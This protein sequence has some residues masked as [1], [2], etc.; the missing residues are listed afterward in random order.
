MA[1]EIIDDAFFEGVQVCQFHI[2]TIDVSRVITA[3]LITLHCKTLL[4]QQKFF[5]N[6]H[7]KFIYCQ[8]ATS[9][10]KTSSINLQ[11]INNVVALQNN[12]VSEMFTLH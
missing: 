9:A 1:N 11:T 10:P 4:H 6:V 3:P 12:S 7:W 8:K 5:Q 2:K